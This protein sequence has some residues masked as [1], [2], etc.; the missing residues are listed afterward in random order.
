M[1][2]YEEQYTAEE[3]KLAE[4]IIELERGALSSR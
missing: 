4:H 1:C 2:N 3:K